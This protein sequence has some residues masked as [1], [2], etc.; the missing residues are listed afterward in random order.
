MTGA[1]DAVAAFGPFRLS[2]ATRRIERDGIPLEL[3]QR[4]LDI[5]IA[6]VDRAGE[7]VSH[8]ELVAQT[9]RDL[10]VSPGNLRVHM[11]AL[12]K[13][14]GDGVDGARYIENVTGQ[15]YCFVATVHRSAAPASN[16]RLPATVP[17]PSRPLPPLLTRMRGRDD[18]VRTI[19]A[20]IRKDRFVTIV[21]PG[22][23][24]KTTV[25][26]TVA[27]ALVEEFSGKV[28]FVDFGAISDS[29]LLLPTVAS[30]LGLA[31][32][33]EVTQTPLLAF[34]KDTRMLLVL[35]NCEHVID[36]AAALAEA[37]FNEA[38][39]VYILATS[40][41]SLRVEGEHA[42]WLRPLESPPPDQPVNAATALEF[43][44]IALFVD[45][46]SRSGR[47]ELT[48]DNAHLIADICGRLDGVALALELVGGR[49][50]TYGLE[51]TAELLDK[52]LGL[53]WQGR[54]TALPRHQTLHAL[55]DWSYG[56][57]AEQEQRVLRRLSVF[58]GTF[59]LDA[60]QA[61]VLDGELDDI[62]IASAI[63]HL[64][65]K[66]LVTVIRGEQGSG[67]YRL[68]ETT[69][70]FALERLGTAEEFH[71]ARQ[72]HAR[73]LV[74]LLSSPSGAA[75]P[76]P[77]R[78][79]HLGNLRS[80]L[81]WCFAERNGEDQQHQRLLGADLTA[82]AA[83]VF[84]ECSLWTECLR[85]CVAALSSLQESCRGDRRELVLQEAL[86][87]SSWLARIDEDQVRP[88]FTRAIEIAEK[89]GETHVRF[90]L[91]AGLQTFL[92]RTTDYDGLR[93]V[94]AEMEAMALVANDTAITVMADWLRGSALH[95]LGN[96]LEA[97]RL[98]E[99]G[100]ARGPVTLP[101]QV[102]LDYRVRAQVA[103]ARV[104]WLNGSPERAQQ[105]AR[106]AMIEAVHSSKS[107]NICFVYVFTCHVFLWSGDLDAAQEILEKMLA[108]PHWRG[109]VGF[110]A[111]GL[112]L[113][114]ELL[115]RRGGFAAGITLLERALQ[116]MQTRSQNLQ[117]TLAACCLAEALSNTG[118][119][120][121][122]RAVIDNAI[123]R[124][125]EGAEALEMPEVLRIK[126][127]ILLARA[128]DDTTEAAGLLMQS[129]ASARRQHAKGWELRTTC[130]LAELRAQTG[131][132]AEARGLLAPMLEQFNEGFQTRDLEAAA[133]LLSSLTDSPGSQTSP[134]SR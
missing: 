91:L 121:E 42:H 80:A 84:M 99:S 2:P 131:Q 55:L 124:V 96:Q 37:I 59:T 76:K 129:L 58:V 107:L 70:D 41:E 36:S 16:A 95:F 50:A 83:P 127:G 104:L 73:H 68:L 97:R 119:F 67:R 23:M 102:G 118:H 52:R 44:A 22:G 47:F 17:V 64:V 117:R 40:R 51:G 132:S 20:D 5:L 62:R 39:G 71:A 15:G 122:A 33:G 85:W 115:V 133:N 116:D 6:L 63:D 31:V 126:A 60:A 12:R 4:A 45:C 74:R 27:H 82:A 109:L 125:P 18:A 46:A 89:L 108:H 113:Q 81:E 53:F 114:G 66:S 25:A 69:R 28:C 32:Q 29:R 26:V 13:A 57:L 103:F 56:L 7:V 90:R 92:I 93:A 61:V 94:C 105:A 48:D 30:T 10:V 112:A 65:S 120:D 87:L 21:G 54:R 98:L 106:D 14:L 1:D 128:K 110:H 34:L 130:M 100:F 75:D 3:G 123:A 9:W 111:E 35:D 72:R 49:I 86:G 134:S 88:A 78:H 11:S 19:T 8:R 101:G 38:P 77:M 24:G 43:S 79:E